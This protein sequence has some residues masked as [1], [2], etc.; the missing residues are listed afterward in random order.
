MR[1]LFVDDDPVLLENLQR[2]MADMAGEWDMVFLGSG[3]A[4][5]DAFAEAPFDVVVSDL[6]MPGMNGADFLRE[7]QARYPG[8]IRFILS[9]SSDRELAVQLVERAHQFLAKPCQ[10]A[11]LK[12]AVTRALHLGGR[13]HS[14]RAKE[15]VARLGQLP[16][17]PSLYLEINALLDS[18]RA[19]LENLS[20]IIAKDPAMTTMILKL[21][22]SAFFNLRNT[23]SV[24]SEALPY[25]G[26]DLLKSLV[27]A[28]GLFNQMAGFRTPGFS[29]DH[30][31]AHSLSVAGTAQ[32]I[33]EAE[34]MGSKFAAECFTAGILHDVGILI[35]ASRF[36]AEYQQ[37]L[38]T[39]LREG[40]DLE[41]AEHHVLGASHSEVG[42]Y[43]LGLWGLPTAI[44]QATAWHNHPRN[45]EGTGFSPTIAVHVANVLRAADHLHDVFDRATLDEAYLADLGLRR[46]LEAWRKAGMGGSFARLSSR[47]EDQGGRPDPLKN[48]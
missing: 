43:L 11:F 3:Q 6:W 7:V 39:N 8:C 48:P 30:L 40:S 23:V 28:H 10:P 35:L 24:P 16:A 5:L 12:T 44:V 2:A 31:W 26:V 1:A 4:G 37:V 9:S 29:V 34:A 27:L 15:L 41:F 19:T 13:V 42:S 22:N 33:A 46:R 18:N 14:E 21:A 32:R 17:I 45:Q 38:E 25:L 20:Q 36:P 47:S